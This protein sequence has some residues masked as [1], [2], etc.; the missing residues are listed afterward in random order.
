LGA[1][2]LVP[3]AA[4][5][6]GAPRLSGFAAAGDGAEGPPPREPAAGLM[7]ARGE[8]DELAAPRD[9]VVG[10]AAPRDGAPGAPLTL[11]RAAE[12][13]DV[14]GVARGRPADRGALAAAIA[15]LDAGNIVGGSGRAGRCFE[16]AGRAVGTAG[17][18]A[19]AGAGVAA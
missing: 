11:G 9:A 10:L 6:L 8:A 16:G 13:A 7:A 19:A 14:E 15:A 17:A 2:V 3:T 5:L 1:L 12:G 4:P 18:R